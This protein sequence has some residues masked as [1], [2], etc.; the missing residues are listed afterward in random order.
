MNN[1]IKVINKFR[2]GHESRDHPFIS[3][4]FLC[5]FNIPPILNPGSDFVKDQEIQT[6]LITAAENFTPPQISITYGEVPGFGGVKKQILLS[7][8]TTPSFSI[9]FREWVNSDNNNQ[10]QLNLFPIFNTW[11]SVIDRH[12]GLYKNEETNPK[13]YKGEIFVVEFTPAVLQ[14]NVNNKPKEKIQIEKENILNIF[15]MYGISPESLPLDNHTH[16]ISN[17]DSQTFQVNFKCDGSIFFSD[18]LK[19]EGLK[20]YV[21]TELNSLLVL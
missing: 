16:D 12:V 13:L 14:T 9:S 2:G 5:F 18:D 8:E 21:V 4:Y 6:W 20:E 7:T 10:V 17:R 15:H 11:A 3:G 19:E 1:L